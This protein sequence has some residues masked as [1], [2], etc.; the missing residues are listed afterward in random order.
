M[1]ENQIAKLEKPTTTVELLL[2]AELG[3]PLLVLVHP[4]V[5]SGTDV[6]S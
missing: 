4:D 6:P 1:I 5:A 2:V 3:E